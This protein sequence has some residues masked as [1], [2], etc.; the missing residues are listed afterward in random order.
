MKNKTRDLVDRWNKNA[1]TWND[2]FGAVADP[3]RMHVI[4]PTLIMKLIGDIQGKVVVDAGCGNGYLCKL[5]ASESAK[6]VIGIDLSRGM[7]E[8]SSKRVEN[9][10]NISLVEANLVDVPLG[11]E[12]IDAIVSITVLSNIPNYQQVFKQWGRILK[13]GAPLVFATLH[14]CFSGNN[15]RSVRLENGCVAWQIEDYFD[16]SPYEVCFPGYPSSVVNHPRT[17]SQYFGALYDSGFVIEQLHEPLPDIATINMYPDWF[18]EKG[19]KIPRFLVIKS[20]K[21]RKAE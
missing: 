21:S 1:N 3:I 8:N 12:T 14:P 18:S 16:P 6:Q 11:T 17:L 10:S 13:I 20:V 4:T 9:Q 15:S 2:S 7:L 5:L 19:R